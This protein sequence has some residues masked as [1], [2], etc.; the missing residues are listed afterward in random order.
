[1]DLKTGMLV[2]L[3][4]IAIVGMAVSLVNANLAECN[5]LH[6]NG[7]L[8][9]KYC[10]VDTGTTCACRT[11]EYANSWMSHSGYVTC[12]DIQSNWCTTQGCPDW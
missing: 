10:D 1:M 3:V 5:E 11:I 12:Y 7:Q 9:G 4:G 8:Y 6:Y 2:M